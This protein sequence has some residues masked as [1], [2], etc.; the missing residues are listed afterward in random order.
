MLLFINVWTYRKHAPSKS[1]SIIKV[2]QIYYFGN[3]DSQS[4]FPFKFN[5]QKLL[6]CARIVSTQFNFVAGSYVYGE[7]KSPI[8][9]IKFT[10]YCH[11]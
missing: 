2:L 5:T 9:T 6:L 3:I 10:E 8:F 4:S 11:G 1:S 7:D